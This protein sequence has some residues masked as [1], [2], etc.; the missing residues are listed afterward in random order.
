ML[1]ILSKKEA[2]DRYMDGE[3]IYTTVNFVGFKDLERCS[4]E[5]I[6]EEKDWDGDH[7]FFVQQTEKKHFKTRNDSFLNMKR[8]T[9]EEL[10]DVCLNCCIGL[11]IPKKFFL[12]ENT[13]KT[14]GDIFG[15]IRIMDTQ[16]PEMTFKSLE[17]YSKD[18]NIYEYK[19]K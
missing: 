19:I 8:I 2:I 15:I 9:W 10:R 1:E 16:I 6:R 5:D 11:E 7:I 18:F 13:R 17:R 4:L 3:K 12:L 14:I